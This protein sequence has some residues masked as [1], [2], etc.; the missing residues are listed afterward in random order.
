MARLFVFGIGG[1]GARVIKS[2]T[3]L[4]AAGVKP[5]E[6]DIV[7]ILIDPHKDLPE[8]RDCRKLLDLY[9]KVNR[10]CYATY[11]SDEER[12]FFHAKIQSLSEIADG[13][14]SGFD[15][16]EKMNISFGDFI[17]YNTLQNNDP[18]KDLID[19]LYAEQ[20]LNN[21]LSV[22]FKGNPNIGSVVLNRFDDLTWYRSFESIF[23]SGDRI[24]I[25]SSIFGGTG[26]SG[27]PLL[28]KKLRDSNNKQV[29]NSIIGALPVMPYFKLTEPDDDS[30]HKDIDSNNFITKTKS[31]LIYYEKFLEG[32]NAL[33]Y[34]A[35][36]HEQSK[37]YVNDEQKQNNKAH[38]IEMIGASS[39]MDFAKRPLE[40]SSQ[41][42][43]Q[44]SLAED[45]NRITFQN[46]GNELRDEVQAE[47]INFFIFCRIHG[48]IK[49]NKD[50]PVLKNEKFDERF[51][52]NDFIMEIDEFSARFSKWLGEL[53]ENDRQ[54]SPFN[55][56]ELGEDFHKIV[57]GKEVKDKALLGLKKV[58]F[59]TSNYLNRMEA[60]RGK[61]SGIP[62]DAINTKYLAL[63]NLA[64]HEVNKEKFNY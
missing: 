31:A 53:A 13:V 59:N 2:L 45:S 12:P 3:M 57:V 32:L 36:P 17:G 22:G 8:L 64:I 5:A 33:Y 20:S 6:F 29:R 50:A 54:F 14:N 39:I 24:F 26:A 40:G 4:C 28:L 37:P 47:L 61:L 25:V 23:S 42:F 16:D 41:E 56:N 21:S 38:V 58:T 9:S 11:T 30:A 34:L 19:M 35:D 49:I 44:Y 10:R 43:Y 51:F 18:N 55:M 62:Q 7:P 27:F 1:T 63:V 60:L 52:R 46:L 15:F 48:K